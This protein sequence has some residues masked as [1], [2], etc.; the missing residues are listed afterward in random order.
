MREPVPYSQ[1]ITQVTIFR[2]GTELFQDGNVCK[3]A[4]ARLRDQNLRHR[5]RYF[6]ELWGFQ[7]PKEIT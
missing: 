2:Y 4:W 7:R 1:D 6:Y 3:A 5:I